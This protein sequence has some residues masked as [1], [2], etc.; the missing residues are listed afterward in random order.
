MYENGRWRIRYD[1]SHIKNK[2]LRWAGDVMRTTG[3][4][5]INEKFFRGDQLALDYYE[6]Q[7]SH[8]MTKCSE[9]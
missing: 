2:S 6:D 4:C 8:G 5:L 7:N 9:L 1:S 3:N